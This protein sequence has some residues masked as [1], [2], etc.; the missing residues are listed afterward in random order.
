M[1]SEPPDMIVSPAV[2][3]LSECREWSTRDGKSYEGV[4]LV[5]VV[6]AAQR[7]SQ[8]WPRCEHATCLASSLPPAWGWRGGEAWE[9]PG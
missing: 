6:V 1:V 8:R 7:A 4:V 2:V 5:G 3:Q 9:R